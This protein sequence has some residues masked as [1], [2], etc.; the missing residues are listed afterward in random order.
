MR[1]LSPPQASS[2]GW[3]IYHFDLLHTIGDAPQH[4]SAKIGVTVSQITL[5]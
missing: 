3:Y 1:A 5:S 2:H 4:T